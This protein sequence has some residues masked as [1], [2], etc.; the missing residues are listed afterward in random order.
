MNTDTYLESNIPILTDVISMDDGLDSFSNDDDDPFSKTIS[1]QSES[2]LTNQP[3]LIQGQ[4]LEQLE[5]ALRENVLN[6]LMTRIDFVLEHRVRDSLADVLQI[7]V[8]D[9]ANNIRQGLS[10][11][12]EDV[13]QRAIGQEISKIKSLNVRN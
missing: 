2:D 3:V 12:L 8:D 4:D 13:I 7:A 5:K 11:S 9:L 6:Q 1:L 10:K